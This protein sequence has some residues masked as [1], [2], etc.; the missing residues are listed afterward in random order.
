MH[1]V[2]VLAQDARDGC[3]RTGPGLRAVGVPLCDLSDHIC[4]GI[5]SARLGDTT[6]PK[7]HGE[8]RRLLAQ[9][10]VVF[11]VDEFLFYRSEFL[12]GCVLHPLYCSSGTFSDGVAHP[13]SVFCCGRP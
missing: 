11:S 10:L 9:L 1:G 13:R 12:A 3:L 5:M 8:Q 2:S 6:P 7:K 4:L